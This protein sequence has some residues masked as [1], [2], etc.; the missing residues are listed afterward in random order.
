MNNN[1]PFR[2]QD[3]Y[4]LLWRLELKKFHCLPKVAIMYVAYFINVM[5]YFTCLLITYYFITTNHDGRVKRNH[6]LNM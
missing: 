1:N 6:F 3:I 4:L 5:Q 2:N